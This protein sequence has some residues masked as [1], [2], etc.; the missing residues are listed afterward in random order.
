MLAVGAVSSLAKNPCASCKRATHCSTL[1]E[2][3]L[4]AQDLYRNA[5][6]DGASGLASLQPIIAACRSKDVELNGETRLP[7]LPLGKDTT[8]DDSRSSLEHSLSP[9]H[10]PR[11]V[12]GNDSRASE[13]Y[14]TSTSPLRSSSTFSKGL[15]L[16]NIPSSVKPILSHVAE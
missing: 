3:L 8:A 16:P 10:S 6:P 4:Q 12:R 1:A 11:R 7:Q 14:S 9:N 2:L 5:A 15:K 13:L